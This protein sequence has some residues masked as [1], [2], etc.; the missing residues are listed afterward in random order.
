[1]YGEAAHPR[2]EERWVMRAKVAVDS[3]DDKEPLSPAQGLR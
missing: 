1:M 2:T 3:A